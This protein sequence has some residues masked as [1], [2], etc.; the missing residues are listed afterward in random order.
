MRQIEWWNFSEGGTRVRQDLA[1][2]DGVEGVVSDGGGF[3]A[4][5]RKQ[6]VLKQ[7]R[8]FR[9]AHVFDERVAARHAPRIGPISAS[10]QIAFGLCK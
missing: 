9:A 6:T 5:A 10:R 3:L 2:R 8:P 1:R 4:T 7:G